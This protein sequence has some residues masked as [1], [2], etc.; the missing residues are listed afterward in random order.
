MQ[1]RY[2]LNRIWLLVLL[3][4]SIPVTLGAVDIPA[5][6]SD[7][8]VDLASII[9][10]ETETK[11]NR[12]LRELEQK[13]G[14]QMAILTLTSLEG[15]SLEELSINIAHDKWK[16]GQ[17]SKDNG[18]LMLI[19]LNDRKYRIEIGYGLES[20]LPDGLVGSIG[21]QYLIPYFK[22][23]D[24]SS[25]VYA[26]AVVIA[27]QIAQDAGVEITGL[28]TVKTTAASQ[29]PDRSAGVR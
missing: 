26:A 18:V 20:I 27:N 23:G 10:T 24:Y 3:V 29:R 25:G 4:C 17:K 11:L 16:L 21:R 5:L 15:R 8:V 9:D 28:P 6:P 2:R 19:A 1:S 7:P 12:Y 22:K 13:T 14:A